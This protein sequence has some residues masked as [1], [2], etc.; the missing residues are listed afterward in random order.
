MFLIGRFL[1]FVPLLV[2]YCLIAL[3]ETRFSLSVVASIYMGV[4]IL[5]TLVGALLLRS[6]MVGQFNWRNVLAMTF[7]PCSGI[8]GYGSLMRLC[9]S[10]LLGLV[11][12]GL[13]SFAI[14]RYLRLN[15]YSL[16]RIGLWTIVCG[17][18]WGVLIGMILFLIQQ[19]GKGYYAGASGFQTILKLMAAPA[20]ALAL[21]VALVIIGLP[22]VAFLVAMIPVAIVFAPMAF[23]SLVVIAT[24][25]S[26]KPFRWN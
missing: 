9:M 21:S 22:S 26:G 20:I 14:A 23:L 15:D 8:L 6:A 19:Y 11:L 16:E 10:N 13:A 4:V 3:L 25:L 7:M 17:L 2:L 24:K 12:S 18:A 1:W 5:A